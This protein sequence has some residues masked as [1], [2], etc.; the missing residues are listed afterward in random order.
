VLQR[1]VLPDGR[2]VRT[3]CFQHE[4]TQLPRPLAVKD[5]SKRLLV[6]IAQ[7]EVAA[8]VD[9]ACT[10]HPHLHECTG[11]RT[12]G[13]IEGRFACLD[14]D[15]LSTIAVHPRPRRVSEGGRRVQPLVG[16]RFVAYNRP[17]TKATRAVLAEALKLEAEARAE[18]AAEILASLDGPND[19][20]A[21]GAWALEIGRRVTAIEQG[22]ARLEPWDDVKRRIEQG[23]RRR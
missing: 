5:V 18:L 17:M 16:R 11:L 6:D 21:E 12:L 10:P 8:I 3:R 22:T 20:D 19:P 2:T 7:P 23:L 13:D 4:P 1:T 15:R 9:D 14:I